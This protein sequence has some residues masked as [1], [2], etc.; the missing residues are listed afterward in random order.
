MWLPEVLPMKYKKR[1]TAVVV[2]LAGFCLLGGNSETC[3]RPAYLLDS[4]IIPLVS[5]AQCQRSVSWLTK[6][7]TLFTKHQIPSLHFLDLLEYFNFG[8]E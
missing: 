7:Q 6:F 2:L 5:H 4:E 8:D 3:E 1:V